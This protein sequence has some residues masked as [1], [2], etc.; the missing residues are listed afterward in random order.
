[1]KRYAFYEHGKL[2]AE[3][4]LATDAEASAKA[5]ELLA[6]LSFSMKNPDIT[7]KEICNGTKKI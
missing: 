7:F 1:M 6:S 2:I 5:I 4:D 3:F